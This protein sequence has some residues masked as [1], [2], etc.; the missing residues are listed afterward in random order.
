MNRGPERQNHFP[1][2]TQQAC[3]F[4]SLPS[5]PHSPVGGVPSGCGDGWQDVSQLLLGEHPEPW[6]RSGACAG[7]STWT[8]RSPVDLPSLQLR[9]SP[10]CLVRASDT[11]PFHT[12][13]CWAYV[14]G[15]EVTVA[16]S[17]RFS[18]LLSLRY[19]E[20]QVSL[21]GP[22]CGDWAYWNSPSSA[23]PANHWDMS[24]APHCWSNGFL[25]F[26]F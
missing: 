15:E 5:C 3:W 19:W 24:M 12:L 8:W 1:A 22:P 2:V 13:S 16:C 10:L 17:G 4:L 20:V 25:A 14:F 21:G 11:C 6:R 23:G 7:G 9:F 26:T 18:L